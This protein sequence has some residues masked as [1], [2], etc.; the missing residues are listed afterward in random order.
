[1]MMIILCFGNSWGTMMT[2]LIFGNSWGMMMTIL[3]LWQ[4]LGND[5][6]FSEHREKNEACPQVALGLGEAHK[7]SLTPEV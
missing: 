2:I 6:G 4:L 5:G 3:M 1:M 7:A